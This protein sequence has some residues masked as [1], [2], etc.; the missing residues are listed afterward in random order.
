MFDVGREVLTNLVRHQR[1]AAVPLTPTP[2][3]IL[4]C[5]RIPRV[6]MSPLSAEET[7]LAGVLSI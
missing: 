6:T 2:H 1:G 7:G 5:L 3:G 4:G